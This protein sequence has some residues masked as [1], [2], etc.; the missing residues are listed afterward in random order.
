MAYSINPCLV[1]ARKTA[2]LMLL[3]EQLSISVVARR[4]GVH[5]TT[6]WRWYKKWQKLNQNVSQIHYGRPNRRTKFCASYYKWHIVT[7]SSKPHTHPNK[8]SL[9]V[10]ERVIELKG[11]LKRCAEVIW[12]YLVAEGVKISLSSVRRILARNGYYSKKKW[13][14]RPYRRNPKRPIPTNLGDLVQIDTIHLVDPRTGKR[15]YVYT[16]IDLCTR[17]AYAKVYERIYQ[18]PA[19]ETILMAESKFGFKFKVVQSD[20]GHE[21]GR[22][23]KER[24]EHG[25]ERIVRHSRPHRPND[26]AHIERFNRTIREECI[27][28][29]MSI[30]KTID[31]I[32]SKI[33]IFLDYYNNE[34]LHL[35]LKC[36][37]PAEYCHEVLQRW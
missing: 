4:C 27:G 1:T 7:K 37:T 20:N 31:Q 12:H 26:N 36:K 28:R 13:E 3:N 16:V 14:Q 34:R 24:L 10:I 21:F 6:I 22:L 18:I 33:D 5:R 29:Y 15:K 2:L 30:N 9:S 8:L 32:Q 17:M 19:I 35:G 25:D 11:Q 23:F